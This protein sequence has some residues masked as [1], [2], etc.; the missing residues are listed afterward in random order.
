MPNAETPDTSVEAQLGEILEHLRRM[1]ARDKLRMWGGFFRSIIALIPIILLVWSAWYFAQHG[2]EIM[3][4]IA[5]T[6]ASSAA[7]YTQSQSQGVIDEMM[8]KFAMPK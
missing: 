1:D 8:Q 5:D 6:A 4:T 2:T 7:K 3:K